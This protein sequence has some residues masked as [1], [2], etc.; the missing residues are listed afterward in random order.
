MDI[1]RNC[2]D[3]GELLNPCDTYALPTTS[4][5]E[6]LQLA[7]NT[8]GKEAQ[9]DMVIEEMSELT[10]ALLKYRRLE[11]SLKS[12]DCKKTQA[13]QNIYEEIADVIIMLTQL[14]MIYGGRDEIKMFIEGKVL[15]LAERLDEAANLGEQK[16]GANIDGRQT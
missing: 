6:V 5:P 10:K 4:H 9:T 1:E 3:G 8:Y 11:N 15:R 12:A 16:G 14:I 13:K 2:K 7:V